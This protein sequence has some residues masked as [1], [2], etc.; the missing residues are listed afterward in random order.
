MELLLTEENIGQD[1]GETGKVV[2]IEHVSLNR[3]QQI[4]LPAYA[5]LERRA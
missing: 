3:M 5:G 2:Q 1:S 4:T